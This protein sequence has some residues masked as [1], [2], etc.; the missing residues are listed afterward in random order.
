M[1]EEDAARWERVHTARQYTLYCTR[2]GHTHT[3]TEGGRRALAGP[4]LARPGLAQPEGPS[5]SLVPLSRLNSPH[6]SQSPMDTP[7]P[8][9]SIPPAVLLASPLSIV[10][11]ALSPSRYSQINVIQLF[12]STLRLLY[13]TL[14]LVPRCSGAARQRSRHRHASKG[15]PAHRDRRTDGPTRSSQ[16]ALLHH[17]AGPREASQPARTRRGREMHRSDTVRHKGREERP[18][19]SAVVS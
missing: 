14:L 11:I 15:R 18:Y 9:R 12:Y 8:L 2:C 6:P 17:C 1:K 16:R 10:M 19:A 4:G 7:P 3:H 5:A 13:S